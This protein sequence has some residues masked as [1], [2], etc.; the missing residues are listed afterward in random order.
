MV[1]LFQTG[2][3]EL[4]WGNI[5]MFVIALAFI[6]LAIAKGMEP[7]LLIPIGFSVMLVNLPL[8]GLMDG[9]SGEPEGLLAKIFSYLLAGEIIPPLISF[10]Q[11]NYLCRRIDRRQFFYYY[12]VF[13]IIRRNSHNF[14]ASS[15]GTSG[16]QQYT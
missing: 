13:I 14:F 4:Y 6:Y 8:G 12:P 11:N 15:G 5:V 10:P 1:E 9:M 16:N 2:F 3:G 7:L